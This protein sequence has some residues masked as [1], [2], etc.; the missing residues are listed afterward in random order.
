MSSLWI[1]QEVGDISRQSVTDRRRFLKDLA[2]SCAVESPGYLSVALEVV[3]RAA[4]AGCREPRTKF[5]H[6]VECVRDVRGYSRDE[7]GWLLSH[8]IPDTDETR[9]TW[10][11][12]LDE[13]VDMVL[14]NLVGQVLAA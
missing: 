6:L 5:L 1:D 14:D 4:S 13:R 11:G 8:A 2:E 10:A 7:H 3:T 9:E 12:V